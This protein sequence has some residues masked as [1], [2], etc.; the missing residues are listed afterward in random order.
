MSNQAF[1][2][3]EALARHVA[4]WLC[5]RALASDRSFAVFCCSWVAPGA[6]PK[7]SPRPQWPRAFPGEGSIMRADAGTDRS[8]RELQHAPSGS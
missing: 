5:A 2:D 8:A 1:A 6:S 3:A 7:L 4:E